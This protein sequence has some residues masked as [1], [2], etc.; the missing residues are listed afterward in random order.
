MLSGFA[1]LPSL[2]LKHQDRER[3]SEGWNWYFAV[4]I[5]IREK[6]S[7]DAVGLSHDELLHKLP[8]TGYQ[9]GSNF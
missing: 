1:N 4:N 7:S 6:A 8:M 5:V 2:L 9:P 3:P